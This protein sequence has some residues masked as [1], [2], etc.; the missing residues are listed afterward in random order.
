M[1]TSPRQ[2]RGHVI[3]TIGVSADTPDHDVQIAQA[4]LAAITP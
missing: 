4:G 2:P 3:G 1:V